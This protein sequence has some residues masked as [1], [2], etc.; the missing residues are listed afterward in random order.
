MSH[1]TIEKLIEELQILINELKEFHRESSFQKVG[2]PLDILLQS[3]HHLLRELTYRRLQKFLRL[4]D[5]LS[6]GEGGYV[7]ERRYMY[8][9]LVEF[10]DLLIDFPWYSIKAVASQ[11]VEEFLM[12]PYGE[13]YLEANKLAVQQGIPVSRVFIISRDKLYSFPI[14][15]VI[16]ANQ[17]IFDEK[18]GKGGVKIIPAEELEEELR[19]YDFTLIDE[20]I[21]AR[22]DPIYGTCYIYLGEKNKFINKAKDIFEKLWKHPKAQTYRRYKKEGEKDPQV[23]K[24]FR[25]ALRFVKMK[26]KTAYLE[27]KRW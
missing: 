24:L 25:E 7:I 18:S 11:N 9:E 15:A 1:K 20:C 14:I 2:L 13:N 17:S 22:Q 4:Y 19:R 16:T 8:R 10:I 23:A 12:D 3:R 26:Y 21:A 27:N 6:K 5:I